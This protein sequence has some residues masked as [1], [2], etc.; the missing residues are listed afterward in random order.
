MRFL[1]MVKCSENV[2]FPPQGLIDAI[3]QQQEQA[4][5]A[6]I[7]IEVGGLAPTAM[8]ARVR[9]SSGKLTVTDGPFAETKEVIG[10]FAVMDVK[11]KEE[12]IEGARQ[13]MQL[14]IQ[15]WPGWEGEVEIRQ[16]YG[17]EDTPF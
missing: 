8:G 12:A 1:T 4:S 15:H 17:S 2:G 6:G 5:K 11:S 16:M 3:F 9:V 10:G 7:L 13:L 14:H